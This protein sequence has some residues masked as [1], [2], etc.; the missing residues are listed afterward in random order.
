MHF[1][2]LTY[3]VSEHEWPYLIKTAM[4]D[5]AVAFLYL[6]FHNKMHPFCWS[7]LTLTNDLKLTCDKK[8][9]TEETFKLATP[10]HNN[11]GSLKVDW[12][13]KLPQSS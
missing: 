11:V 2:N 13:T 10:F 5:G 3:E 4:T 7:S 9:R 6:M 8:K 1:I 12:I